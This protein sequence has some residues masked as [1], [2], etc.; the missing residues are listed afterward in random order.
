MK[1]REIQSLQP[2]ANRGSLSIE[3]LKKT[4]RNVHFLRVFS[5]INIPLLEFGR[6]RKSY[7]KF[8]RLS[9]GLITDLEEVIALT[10][11]ASM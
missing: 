3:K 8:L 10:L 1:Q 2:L 11:I 5:L 9:H 4:D 6:Q 7:M